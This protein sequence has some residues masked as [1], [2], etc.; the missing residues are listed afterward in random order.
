M[1]QAITGNSGPKVR[2]DIE[3]TLELRASGGIDLDIRSKVKTMYGRAIE[4]QCRQLLDYF[5]IK[6]AR[7]AVN[8]TGALPFVIAA[9]VEAAVRALHASDK[10]FIPEM[11]IENRYSSTR[12]RFRFSRLYLPG[13]SPQ[14]F[15]NAG[16]HSPD[17][18]IL[19]L[20]DSVAP[21]KKDEARILVR[22]AL[23]QVNFYG[24]ERMIR[25]NQ[26]E[27]GLEDLEELIPFN[28]QLVLIPKCEDAGTVK[29]IDEKIRQIKKKAGQE[30]T[31]FLM[32]IIE[33]A[34]GVE[35]AFEIA[36]AA[37]S[38]VSLAIGLED[39]TA[40]LGVQR[41]REGKESLYA[42]TRLVVAAKAAGIQ[43]IDSVFSD[44]GDMEGL[45]ENVRSSKALGFEGMGCI[46]PRQIAVIREGF[47]PTPDEIEKAEKIV[48]AYRE[49]REKGLGVVALG[50]KMIDPPVV[51]RAEKTIN[52]AV[53]LGLLA[54]NRNEEK[55]NQ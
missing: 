25:I 41:T 44:V 28:V 6:D 23:C 10:A 13:N 55:A 51:A 15:L 53:R 40:D 48:S 20:E 5:G 1:K 31:V 18:V 9:R 4:L 49:A 27:R 36:T 47:S 16:L 2:S 29:A 37:S 43:P 30:E 3:V 46:H 21:D 35:N 14:M 32:P 11:I 26:G 7:L 17:G 22:N 52:L 50:T 39:Y 33:S 38:V 19:D 34:K 45:L 54:E 12:E 8:D 24:A 42:R